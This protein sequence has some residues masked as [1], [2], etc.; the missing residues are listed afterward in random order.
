MDNFVPSHVEDTFTPIP[1]EVLKAAKAGTNFEATFDPM[2]GQTDM[3]DTF[4][5]AKHDWGTT[6]SKDLRLQ[7]APPPEDMIDKYGKKI[8]SGATS[9]GNLAM[10]ALTIPVGWMAAF[11]WNGPPMTWE[12][13]MDRYKTI[14]E[15]G[16]IKK[17]LTSTGLSNEETVHTKNAIDDALTTIAEKGFMPSA[18]K[19]FG[20]NPT[21]L[22]ALG[23]QA[24][25]D[26]TMLIAG[27]AVHSAVKAVTPSF[28]GKVAS[29]A[30]LDA[31]RQANALKQPKVVEPATETGFPKIRDDFIVDQ[32]LTESQ[33]KFEAAVEAT[34]PIQQTSV[35]PGTEPLPKLDFMEDV[36]LPADT[37]HPTYLKDGTVLPEGG[38]KSPFMLREEATQANFDN[39][40]SS[41]RS[42]DAGTSEMQLGGKAAALAGP[43]KS[44][45]GKQGGSVNPDVF[46]EGFRK[47]KEMVIGGKKLTFVA[48]H[49]P[50]DSMNPKGNLIIRVMT[51]KGDRVGSSWFS[52]DN[53]YDPF[54]NIVL[55]SKSVGVDHAYQRQ[56]IGTAMYDFAKELGNT[57][58]RNTAQTAAG[59][60]LHDSM[61]RRSLGGKQGGSILNPFYKDK[62][63]SERM[64]RALEKRR[65]SGYRLTETA[66]DTI[67]LEPNPGDINVKGR[68]IITPNQVVQLAEHPWLADAWVRIGGIKQDTAVFFHHLEA[69]LKDTLKQFKGSRKDALTVN[70]K[71]VDIQDPK[72]LEARAAA[73]V[74][75]EATRQF[76]IDQ[77]LEARLVP[78]AMQVLDTLKQVHAMNNKALTS[79]TGRELNQEPLYFP[80]WHSGAYMVKVLDPKLNEVVV[81]GFDS[82]KEARIYEQEIGKQLKDTEF[83][84][85]QTENKGGKDFSNPYSQ[86][87]LEQGVPEFLQKIMDSA[88]STIEQRKYT[89][90]MERAANNVAG[91]VGESLYS[92]N[93]LSKGRAENDRLLNLMHDYLH[94]SRELEVKSRVINEIKR[95]YFD[96]VNLM[97]DKPHLRKFLGEILNREIGHD[98]SQLRGVDGLLQTALETAMKGKDFID[99]KMNGYEYRASE[100]SL[101]PYAAHN[102][103]HAGTYVTSLIKLGWNPPVL[104]TNATAIL[105]VPID[106]LR[107]AMIEGIP[108]QIATNALWKTLLYIGA[109]KPIK[110]GEGIELIDKP[111]EA[112]AFMDK[113][114][115]EG[116][117]EPH[118]SDQ[119]S[120]I[121]A[122]QKGFAERL[123]DLP[124][125]AIE[126][127]TNFVAILYYYNFYKEAFP[128][129]SPEQLQDKVLTTAH[130]YT[131]DYSTQ[132]APLGYSKAGVLGESFTN[133]SKWKWNQIGRLAVDLQQI[134]KA[135]DIGL[136]R[137]VAPLLVTMAQTT[138]L[139]GAIGLPI[140]VEYEALRQAFQKL[141]IADWKPLAGFYRDLEMPT[142][143]TKGGLTYLSDKV[144]QQF[145]EESGPDLSTSLRFSSAL[146]APTVVWKQFYDTVVA[147]KTVLSELLSKANIGEGTSREELKQATNAL[148]PVIKQA[149]M[150]RYKEK[151]VAPD[152]TTT[153]VT[154]SKTKDEGQY[155]QTP[156]ERVL[157][158]GNM[159][160]TK[161]NLA[162]EGMFLNEWQIKD[163]AKQAGQLKK[164]ILNNL[165]NTS[166]VIKNGQKLI[167]LGDIEGLRQLYQQDIPAAEVNRNIDY[168]SKKQIQDAK[169]KDQMRK[170]QAIQ[171][172]MKLIPTS[173]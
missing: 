167:D 118:A 27:G 112:V 92:D 116:M 30:E 147:S 8:A 93:I 95:P 63:Q 20:E 26:A 9:I 28:K 21:G 165:G 125:D 143:L 81:R 36:N 89:W 141:G 160:S 117:I 129:L 169:D 134:G 34:R 1:D 130:S 94:A 107:T 172:L 59:R 7:N 62:A 6:D 171:N 153:Y 98:I 76:L 33:A 10:S 144:A 140:A 100:T 12:Q 84:V 51:D 67:T 55:K 65:E 72:L 25:L 156:M 82:L 56:G 22:A 13:R 132:A 105:T 138:L 108:P 88:E 79:L 152:G 158:F 78:S 40:L 155:T 106:G 173:P 135:G 64:Q 151:H 32:S 18:D 104:A 162:T 24:W 111:S 159:R 83:T 115:R 161:E 137:S 2:S 150:D 58:E 75:P 43:M 103:V 99:A 128:K 19:Y 136:A 66:D 14:T 123:V 77:G 86:L 133:F 46:T 168:F 16:D 11:P 23:K 74:S 139:A 119:F 50:A 69:G 124:R 49:S 45:G 102:L 31:V 110:L 85:T 53:P 57:V 61:E 96:D 154:Q 38:A 87:L 60:A 42:L 4:V 73:A 47:I 146:E 91:F 122:K 114:R 148:P 113:M 48:E 145:G 90:E 126:K 5:P 109:K 15:A 54:P 131:G 3:Q 39:S 37:A 157:N 41:D 149:V 68:N 127:G 166:L 163:R 70:K 121:E 71:L 164:A 35:G 44:L 97:A 142:W 170:Q 52:P 17:W 29:P 80:R 120:T 101:S